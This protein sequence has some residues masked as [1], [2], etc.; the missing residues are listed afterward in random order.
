MMSEL[1]A[2]SFARQYATINGRECRNI[3]A[4]DDAQ[5][6]EN[7]THLLTLQWK[8]SNSYPIVA[9]VADLVDDITTYLYTNENK[10][11]GE[12]NINSFLA[13]LNFHDS[14]RKLPTIKIQGCDHVIVY[15]PEDYVT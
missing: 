5:C 2:R 4:C 9:K 1:L 3:C 10:P 13:P 8:L 6:V 14:S 12:L 11:V 7:A 15:Q